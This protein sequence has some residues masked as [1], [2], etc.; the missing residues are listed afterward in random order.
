MIARYRNP[1][2]GYSESVTPL[3][4]LG[5]GLLGPIWFALQGLWAHAVILLLLVMLLSGFFLFWPLLLLVWVGYAIA[6]PWLLSRSYLRK[7]WVRG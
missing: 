6:A 5:A 4:I 7:G 2:N 3:S 1:A